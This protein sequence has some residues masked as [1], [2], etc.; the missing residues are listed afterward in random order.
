M[1][2]QPGN[3]NNIKSIQELR[4]KLI[5]PRSPATKEFFTCDLSPS[6]G[7]VLCRVLQLYVLNGRLVY[8]IQGVLK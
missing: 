7:Q 5:D 1:V 4:A 3:P 8:E 6:D 2:C